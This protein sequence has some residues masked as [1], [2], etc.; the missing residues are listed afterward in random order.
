M[1]YSA[2][3]LHAQFGAPFTLLQQAREEHHTPLGTVQKFIY[4]LCRR[5]KL[6]TGTGMFVSCSRPRSL[7]G[8][9]CAPVAGACRQHIALRR[10]RSRSSPGCLHR[11]VDHLAAGLDDAGG[12]ALDPSTRK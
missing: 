3:G 9:H 5:I 2:D 11:A 6:M 1:R 4:C 8:R 7:L 12:G 10:C